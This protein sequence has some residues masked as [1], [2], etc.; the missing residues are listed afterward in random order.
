MGLTPSSHHQGYDNLLARPAPRLQRVFRLVFTLKERIQFF[1]K[2]I[3]ETAGTGPLRLAIHPCFIPCFNT[4]YC[5]FGKATSGRRLRPVFWPNMIIPP[6]CLSTVQVSPSQLS[7]ML[8]LAAA[9]SD[10]TL[11]TTAASVSSFCR[12]PVVV[13]S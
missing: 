11:Q 8:H 10:K 6:I 7:R 5:P 3:A 1:P 4:Q 13:C 12:L 2:V 9:A